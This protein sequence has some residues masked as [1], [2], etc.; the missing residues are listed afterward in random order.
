[1]D[2]PAAVLTGS[3]SKL[4]TA[5]G[6][7]LRLDQALQASQQAAQQ[8]SLHVVGSPRQLIPQTV[9]AGSGLPAQPRQVA[10]DSGL[11]LTTGPLVQ[12]AAVPL[13]S[14]PS[15]FVH[16]G[17]G[18]PGASGG[19]TSFTASAF[20]QSRQEPSQLTGMV[21]VAVPAS[22]PSSTVGQVFAPALVPVAVAPATQAPTSLSV[23][24]Q[25]IR[26]LDDLLDTIS[27]TDSDKFFEAPCEGRGGTWVQL[28]HC[29]SHVLPD[30]AAEG[31]AAGVSHLA[32][33]C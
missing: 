5:A 7:K 31:E 18:L 25:Q 28:C 29:T 3:G 24:E 6:G 10:A 30:D 12:F 1:M 23:A 8:S 11:G 16:N 15:A 26:V 17:P 13:T 22:R 19:S 32:Q 2:P 33:L 20:K 9:P 21:P 27:K 14:S 4:D